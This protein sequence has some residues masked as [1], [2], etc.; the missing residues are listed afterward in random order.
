MVWWRVIRKNDVWP[1]RWMVGLREGLREGRV[2][3]EGEREGG[4]EREREKGKRERDS[5]MCCNESGIMLLLEWKVGKQEKA[6]AKLLLTK[7][8]CALST[9]MNAD[10]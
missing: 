8:F 1:D 6:R 9:T 10:L 3:G 7:I 2:E 5:S 4:R